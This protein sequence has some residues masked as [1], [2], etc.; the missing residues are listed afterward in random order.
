LLNRDKIQRISEIFDGPNCLLES[1]ASTL[2]ERKYSGKCYF[3]KQKRLLMMTIAL[4]RV[5]DNSSLKRF[6]M[7][8]Q[9]MLSTFL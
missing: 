9:R 1:F 3:G 7:E 5:G 6:P 8:L 4:A 2:F